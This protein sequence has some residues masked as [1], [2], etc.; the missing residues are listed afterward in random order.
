MLKRVPKARLAL[1][2]HLTPR[3]FPIVLREH[4]EI[5]NHNQYR[6]RLRNNTSNQARPVIRRVRRL[7]RIPSNDPTTPAT[8]DHHRRREGLLRIA[9]D[10]V[11]HV[12][13]VRRDVRINPHH[14]E[15]NTAVPR[16]HVR[17]V[18]DHGDADDVE[19][20]VEDDDVA[21][22]AP[23][24]AE[25][26]DEEHPGDAGGVGREGQHLGA[27]DR[28]A[29]AVVEDDGQEVGEGVEA[30]V[31]EADEGGEF[32]E[33]PVQGHGQ[34]GVQVDFLGTG[35]AKRRKVSVYVPET[36]EKLQRHGVHHKYMRRD[37]NAESWSY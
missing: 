24:V 34:D 15:E 11:L 36:I 26:G 19:D 7:E 30:D 6:D 4:V 31:V 2:D 5:L 1:Y 23:A 28:V 16:M 21:A 10:V 13:E 25:P 8:P 20:A 9:D 35:F 22:D 33:F 37:R 29:E 14:S 17:A 18:A 27:R 12:R 3:R 32:P